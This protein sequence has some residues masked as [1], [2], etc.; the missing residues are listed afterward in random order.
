MQKKSILAAVTMLAL[1]AGSTMVTH[2]ALA[3]GELTQ[4]EYNA[5]ITAVESQDPEMLRDFLR[6]YPDS[7]LIDAI[8][9]EWLAFDDSIDLPSGVGGIDVTAPAPAI[10]LGENAGSSSFSESDASNNGNQIY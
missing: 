10:V 6:T 4:E 5:F 3:E 1:S 8:T 7:I 2:D 9:A